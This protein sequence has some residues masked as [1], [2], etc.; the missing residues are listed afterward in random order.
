MEQMTRAIHLFFLL[1]VM[2]L[3]GESSNFGSA[4]KVYRHFSSEAAVEYFVATD[5]SDA[6]EVPGT[7]A[8]PWRTL[9]HAFKTLQKLRPNPPQEENDVIVYL[10]AGTYHFEDTLELGKRDSYVTLKNYLEEEVILSGGFPL[11]LTWK[12][13]GDIFTGMRHSHGNETFLWE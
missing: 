4:E 12:K 8:A 10:R 5:G 3:T 7:L 11:D 9:H 6:T 2:N 1:I 13:N